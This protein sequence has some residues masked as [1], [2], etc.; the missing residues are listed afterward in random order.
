VEV[1]KE[2]DREVIGVL[3]QFNSLKTK[4]NVLQSWKRLA[5]KMLLEY[6]VCWTW[7]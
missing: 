2:E 1:P 5:G 3:G 6:V 7:H 4:R